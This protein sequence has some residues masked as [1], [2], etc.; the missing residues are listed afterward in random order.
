MG[1]RARTGLTSYHALF[2]SRLHGHEM[3]Q[4]MYVYSVIHYCAILGRLEEF[5]LARDVL[6][7]ETRDNEFRDL[8]ESMSGQGKNSWPGSRQANSKKARLCGRCH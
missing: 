7:A 8:S 3:R 4:M 6:G 1:I 5:P 2:P